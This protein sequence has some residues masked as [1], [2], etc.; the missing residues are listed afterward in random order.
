[1]TPW[2]INSPSQF[3]PGGPPALTSAQY[4]ADYNETKSMGN[5]LS[6]TRTDAQTLA[7]Q[8]WAAATATYLWNHVAVS[9]GAQRQ[10][11]L[12]ENARLVALLNVAM[13]DAAIAC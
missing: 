9:L 2:V 6:T 10:T 11:T 13:A 1:M 5:I 8:F 4:A 7:C 3:R 12:S